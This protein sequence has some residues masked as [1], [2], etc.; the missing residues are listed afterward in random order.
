MRALLVLLL[1]LAAPPASAEAP[2]K[3]AV[4]SLVGDTLLVVQREMSTGTRIDRNTRTPVPLNSAALDNAMVLAVER[5]IL[6]AEPKAEV[7]LLAARRPELYALQSRSLEDQ[8]AFRGL[9]DAVRGV[10]ARAEATHLVLVSK[11]RSR[12]RLEVSDGALGDGQLEGLGFYV[13]P[14]RPMDHMTGGQ[15]SE[16]FIASYAWFQVTLVDLGTGAVLGQR[17]ATESRSA[18]S[19]KV[20]TPWQALSAEQK[21]AML[22]QLIV[23]GAARAVPE[24]LGRPAR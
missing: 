20:L 4:L 6:R 21:A 10:A 22:E 23:A 13:D 3:Y 24:L 15:R 18:A 14:T 17:T 11:H 19:Q 5:E 16:G 7:V 12:A 9:V 1:A 8:S 2:R